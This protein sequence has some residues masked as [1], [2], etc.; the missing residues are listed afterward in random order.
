MSET[1][2]ITPSTGAIVASGNYPSPRQAAIHTLFLPGIALVPAELNYDQTVSLVADQF[3]VAMNDSYAFLNRLGLASL[4]TGLLDPY[5]V[6]EYSN[7]IT[8]GVVDEIELHILPNKLTSVL[9]GRDK[10]AYAADSTVY[11]TYSIDPLQPVAP[12]VP[13]AVPGFPALPVIP[14]VT[15]PL[16]LHGFRRA[17]Q[18]AKDLAARVGL[19]LVWNTYDYDLRED[20]TVSGPVLSAIQS[21][22]EPFSHFERSKVDIWAEGGSL[23]VRNR[24]LGGAG[25]S[26]DIHDSRITDLVLKAKFTGYVRVL[27]I[28]G[29]QTG[30]HVNIAVDP[31][32]STEVT[33]EEMGSAGPSSFQSSAS[34]VTYDTKIVTT[35]VVRILDNAQKSQTVETFKDVIDAQGVLHR[36]QLVSLKETI[37]DWDELSLIFPNTIVNRPKENSRIT[38]ESAFDPQHPGALAPLNRTTISHHYSLDGYLTAQNTTKEVWDDTPTPRGPQGWVLDSSETKQYQKNGAGTYQITTTQFGSDG[39]PGD[40]RRTIANG[41]P[42]GGPGRG[43]GQSAVSA[44]QQVTFATLISTQPGAKDVTIN[45]K[46]LLPQHLTIIAQQARAQNGSTE[47]EISFTAAGM[48]WLRRGQYITLTNLFA[49][50]GTTPIVLPSALVTEARIEYRESSESPTYLTYCKA[51]YWEDGGV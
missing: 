31:G 23:I 5:L 12:E 41:T 37:S 21:L 29:S 39:T 3:E 9:R 36:S 15:V 19:G 27:R 47:V 30:T 44:D 4:S 50:D 51:V 20:I 24:G 34:V 22:A 6:P 7:H 32:D 38:I 10:A 13:P 28:L 46:S 49:E 11:L 45:N 2:S 25:L 16:V 17:S 8:G 42:P 35:S 40:V 48:P 14:G 43:T 18:I 1:V 26:M 33:T